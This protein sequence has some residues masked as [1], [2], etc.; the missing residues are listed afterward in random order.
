MLDNGTKYV[1]YEAFIGPIRLI[2]PIKM[3]KAAAVLTMPKVNRQSQDDKE[4]FS[5]IG[6]QINTKGNMMIAPTRMAPIPTNEL[7]ILFEVFDK[8]IPETAYE[9]EAMM[10]KIPEK[11]SKLP[12]GPTNTNSPAKPSKTPPILCIDNS[13]LY[14]EKS[15]N[16]VRIG[17]VACNIDKDPAPSFNDAKENNVNGKAV[18]KMPIKTNE[19][20]WS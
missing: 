5:N 18:F 13:F 3:T 11:V 4:I 9:M 12:V 19:K 2:R 8:Q 15:N 1:T 16:A 7:L 17:T 6:K 20:P 14:K 10:H